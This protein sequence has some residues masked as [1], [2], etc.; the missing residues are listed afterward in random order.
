MDANN[1]SLPDSKAALGHLDIPVTITR[2][3]VVDWT[4]TGAGRDYMKW[5]KEPFRVEAEL[6]DNNRT[7]KIFLIPMIAEQRVN[8]GFEPGREE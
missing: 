7:L 1:P 3:E 8:R 4:P 2:L 5:V 6:Q